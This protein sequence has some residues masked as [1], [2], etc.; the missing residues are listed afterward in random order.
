MLN[1]APVI[2]S[3]A[4]RIEPRSPLSEMAVNRP[5]ILLKMPTLPTLPTQVDV[6]DTVRCAGRLALHRLRTYR[7]HWSKYRSRLNTTSI[8]PAHGT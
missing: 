7:T 8:F 6:F 1:T 2:Q 4:S 3:R 5:W